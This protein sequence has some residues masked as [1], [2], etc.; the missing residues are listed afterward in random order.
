[1]SI[2]QCG[3]TIKNGNYLKNLRQNNCLYNTTES[4]FTRAEIISQATDLL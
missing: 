2:F 4:P 3:N 1:M